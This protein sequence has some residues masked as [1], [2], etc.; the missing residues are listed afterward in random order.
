M[1]NRNKREDMEEIQ[2]MANSFFNQLYTC[3]AM[4]DPTIIIPL[5]RPLVSDDM[6]DELCKPFTEQEI[7]DALFQIGPLKAPGPDGFPA[8]FFQHNWGLI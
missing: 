3:D 4:V 8:R 5:V 7:S 1:Q 2:G 6:N